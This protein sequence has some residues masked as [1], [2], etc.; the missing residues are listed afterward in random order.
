MA[1]CG[2]NFYGCNIVDVPQCHECE[3]G[4]WCRK[5]QAW[6]EM[7]HCQPVVDC[8]ICNFWC[9]YNERGNYCRNHLLD[10]DK[11]CEDCHL[12]YALYHQHYHSNDRN[13]C[14]VCESWID[15][16][17]VEDHAVED[18]EK[19]PTCKRFVDLYH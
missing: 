8:P 5:C 1:A 4:V 10:A 14:K 13:N 18:V 6:I 11:F 2:C 19:C 7:H 9:E 17:H 3:P 16:N 12:H 15:D